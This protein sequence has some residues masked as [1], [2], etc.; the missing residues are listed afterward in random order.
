[1]SL[2]RWN[3]QDRDVYSSNWRTYGVYEMTKTVMCTQA[4]DVHMVYMLLCLL[5]LLCVLHG[6]SQGEL[7]EVKVNYAMY[8]MN[9][10]W[11]HNYIKWK[12]QQIRDQLVAV[13]L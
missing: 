5:N 12:G 10:I 3:D 4:T 11:W 1:M 7:R 8:S 2:T 6:L 9:I 13:W